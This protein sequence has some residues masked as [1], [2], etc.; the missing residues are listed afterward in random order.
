M[1]GRIML[2]EKNE[3]SLPTLRMVYW[4]IV[5]AEMQDNNDGI[6]CPVCVP[7]IVLLNSAL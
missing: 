4:E 3:P 7:V 1:V 2:L 5:Q 6:N